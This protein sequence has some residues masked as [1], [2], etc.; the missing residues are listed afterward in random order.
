MPLADRTFSFRAP[1]QLAER[2][3]LAEQAYGDL[4]RDPATAARITREL[5][6][7]LLRRLHHDPE[8]AA[9]QGRV[10]RAVTEAFVGAVERAMEEDDVIE[11]LRAFDRLDTHGEAER[12]ALL[13]ASSLSRDV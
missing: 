6:T 11:D 10:L 8:H 5:E 7:E 4:A 9:V 3:R 12:R 13:R 1:A 2:L